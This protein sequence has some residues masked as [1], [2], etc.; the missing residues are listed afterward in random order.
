M[1]IF[2]KESRRLFKARPFFHVRRLTT[3][4]IDATLNN[5]WFFWLLG[6]VRGKPFIHTV[7]LC[8]AA[9]EKY[10][11]HYCYRRNIKRYKWRPGLAGVFRQS[12][13]WGIALAITA[14][15]RDL[16]KRENAHR[17]LALTQEVERIQHL[18]RSPN[19]AYS[20]ILPSILR[21]RGIHKDIS[22]AKIAA[23]CVSQAVSQMPGLANLQVDDPIIVLGAGGLVGSEVIKLLTCRRV[24]KVDARV[25]NDIRP[26]IPDEV[27]GQPGILL[28][29][30]RHGTIEYYISQFWKELVVLNEVYPP[31]SRRAKRKLNEMGVRIFH[32]AGV[33]GTAFPNFPAS[34]TGSIPCCAAHDRSLHVNVVP[35]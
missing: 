22:E 32:I 3:L 13:R 16:V 33:A 29:V 23:L 14:T 5:K 18:L 35:V 34:Y 26:N 12:G 15:E 27:R 21:S 19:R 28:D 9:S 8:Y 24:Y 6:R 20:G 2:G 10:A 30:S 4:G 17:L 1:P 7:F 25:T 11:L 31:P